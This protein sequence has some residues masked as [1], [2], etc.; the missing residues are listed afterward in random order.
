MTRE[1]KAQIQIQS[2][3]KR[4]RHLRSRKILLRNQQ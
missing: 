2:A 4:E 1:M 3:V